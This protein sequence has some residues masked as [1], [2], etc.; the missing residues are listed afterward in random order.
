[1]L[2]ADACRRQGDLAK[3][4]VLWSKAIKLQGVA[5]KFG[6]SA[7]GIA[8]DVEEDEGEQGG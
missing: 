6:C 7:G 2:A 1:M 4:Q 5:N 3:W 8:G